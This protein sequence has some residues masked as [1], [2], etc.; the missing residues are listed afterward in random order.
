ME[1]LVHLYVFDTMADWEPGYLT[2]EIHSNRYFRKGV[3]KYV[4][5]T[6]GINTNPVLTMGGIRIYPDISVDKL[7]VSKSSLLI[8]PGGDTWLNPVHLPIIKITEEFLAEGKPVA[9]ICGA[10]A[11][12]AEAGI[13]NKRLHTSNDLQFLKMVC[14]KYRGEE[15]YRNEPAVSDGLLVTASGLA[16]LEFAREALQ[17]LNVFSPDTLEAWYK[18][19]QTKEAVYFTNLMSSLH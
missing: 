8:L 5:Q 10:T 9:A 19:H 7:H 18:L 14:P 2:A 15:Y 4:I 3:S 11:S 1:K 16:P 13:L 17:L 6:V 12:L